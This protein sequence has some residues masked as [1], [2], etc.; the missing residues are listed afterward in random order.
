MR[1][2]R[3]A[4]TLASSDS[5]AA[6]SVMPKPS[7]AERHAQYVYVALQYFRSKPAQRAD[8]TVT[9]SQTA[10]TDVPEEAIAQRDTALHAGEGDAPASA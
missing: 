3:C 1:S 8:L 7:R 10:R 9:A 5:P 6:P 2:A 4:I